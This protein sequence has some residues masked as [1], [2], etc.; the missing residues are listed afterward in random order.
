LYTSTPAPRKSE[1]TASIKRGR[2]PAMIKAD[3]DNGSPRQHAIWP[4]RNSNCFESRSSSPVNHHVPINSNRKLRITSSFRKL[5]ASSPAPRNS[6]TVDTAMIPPAITRSPRRKLAWTKARIQ[7]ARDH[8]RATSGSDTQEMPSEPERLE[9]AG[10]TSFG[11]MRK[12]SAFVKDEELM[13]LFEDRVGTPHIS[14]LRLDDDVS[15]HLNVEE[16]GIAGEVEALLG[17]E[18]EPGCL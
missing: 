14:E 16:L 6:R 11:P 18:H 5:R 10:A 3:D 1:R 7:H 17:G 8:E 12:Q 15:A 13:S 4:L 2:S 9:E